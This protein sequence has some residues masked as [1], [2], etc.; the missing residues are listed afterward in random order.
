MLKCCKSIWL[1]F[2]T[3][4]S[5]PDKTGNL[6]DTPFCSH[7][8]ILQP[9][10]VPQSESSGTSELAK[11]SQLAECNRQLLTRKKKSFAVFCLFTG[12][13]VTVRKHLAANIRLSPLRWHTSYLEL[14][15]KL[16]D[17]WLPVLNTYMFWNFPTWIIRVMQTHQPKIKTSLIYHFHFVC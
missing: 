12:L 15:L 10:L 1:K 2:S 14:S 11:C 16:R 6:Y 9:F 3:P 5:F 7:Y 4:K 17:W 8:Y 13:S